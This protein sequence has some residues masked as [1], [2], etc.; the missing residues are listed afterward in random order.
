VIGRAAP[1]KKLKLEGVKTLTLR[2]VS[3]LKNW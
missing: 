1:V 2:L 3:M